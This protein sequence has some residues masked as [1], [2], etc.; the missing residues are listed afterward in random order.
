MNAGLY[1]SICS[2]N[3]SRK[4]DRTETLSSGW[5]DLHPGVE[6]CSWLKTRAEAEQQLK[7]WP[8][9]SREETVNQATPVSSW[10]HSRS[11]VHL[12]LISV[13]VLFQ[14]HWDIWRHTDTT[15]SLFKWLNLNIYANSL[16][17]AKT[18]ADKEQS[19][20]YRH[21]HVHFSTSEKQKAEIDHLTKFCSKFWQQLQFISSSSFQSNAL[22]F[23]FP[24]HWV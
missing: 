11:A 20:H 13:I 6:P 18:Q 17:C 19:E 1:G 24:S 21:L 14:V 23:S 3:K 10:L 12:H 8:G 2:E 15:V 7:S 4:T 22:C 9:V 16:L 5:P